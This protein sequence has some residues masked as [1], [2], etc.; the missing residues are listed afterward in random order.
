MRTYR[1]VILDI[2]LVLFRN[3]VQ[4]PVLLN[5]GIIP[6]KCDGSNIHNVMLCRGG[7]KVFYEEVKVN[8][9]RKTDPRY[10]R[11]VA[12]LLVKEF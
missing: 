7:T 1:S 8:L 6:K 5:Y 12:P 10:E 4:N 11:A 2:G 3:P 9:I